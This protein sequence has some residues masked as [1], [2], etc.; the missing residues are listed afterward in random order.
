MFVWVSWEMKTWRKMKDFKPKNWLDELW[1]PPSITIERERTFV[2]YIYIQRVKSFLEI[3]S[4][5]QEIWNVNNHWSGEPTRRW[6]Y[7]R[8]SKYGH[9]HQ[10]YD[11]IIQKLYTLNV[12]IIGDI[13]GKFIHEKNDIVYYFQFR[14]SKSNLMPKK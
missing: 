14:T 9:T 4:T 2:L 11:N 7:M 6:Y 3:F 12:K 8:L 1:S 5:F 13:Y 10:K